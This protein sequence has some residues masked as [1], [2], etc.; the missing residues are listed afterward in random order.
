MVK[1][2]EINIFLIIIAP[3]MASSAALLG[4]RL[5]KKKKAV[6]ARSKCEKCN[7][8]IEIYDLIPVLSWLFLNGNTRC[9][10]SKIPKYMILTEVAFILTVIFTYFFVNPEEYIYIYLLCYF[11]FALSFSDGLYFRIPSI[12]VINIVLLGLV[13]ISVFSA[14]LLLFKIAIAGAVF[15]IFSMLQY[16][17]LKYKKINALGGGDI[18]LFTAISM[19]INWQFLTLLVMIASILGIIWFFS[20]NKININYVSK[21]YIPFGVFISISTIIVILLEKNSLIF[22][23]F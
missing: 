8:N 19:W 17:Y 5:P 22:K 20:V 11:L 13:Y 14:D 10:D 16:Y 6:F 9:C 18:K 2:K 12:L 15:A 3:F 23:A 21:K 7:K 4:Y 1:M